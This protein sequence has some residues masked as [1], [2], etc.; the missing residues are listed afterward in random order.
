M[1]TPNYS[2]YAMPAFYVLGLLPQFYATILIYRATNG[3]FN[4]A[5]PRGQ[6]SQQVYQ[7][8][9]DAATYAK[10]ERARGAHMNA[11]EN[12]PLFF[13]AV[14]SANLAG[15]DTGLVNSVCGTFLGLRALHTVWYI[16]VTD[17]NLAHVRSLIWMASSGCCVYLM[18]K[19]GSVLL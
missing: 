2:I 17:Q 19:A 1:S 6:S 16:A 12:L 8:S 3:R 10:F 4:N 7:K 11:M 13:G 14:I 9:T 5:N 15:L 18:V